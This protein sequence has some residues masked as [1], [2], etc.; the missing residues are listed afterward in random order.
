M[1]STKTQTATAEKTGRKVANG[2]GNE[3]MNNG[4]T[5]SQ[6]LQNSF[7]EFTQGAWVDP[8][9]KDSTG[10]IE[11][12]CSAATEPG[13]AIEDFRQWVN[14]EY[15]IDGFCK[16]ATNVERNYITYE[17]EN[18]AKIGFKGR[19]ASVWHLREI[20]ELVRGGVEPEKFTEIFGESG[21][22]TGVIEQIKELKRSM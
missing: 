11:R 6:R 1:H 7:K 21:T 8:F 18:E 16:Y 5:R 3:L 4:A 19:G 13:K 20:I 9:L 14:D 12:M 15:G 22:S 2:S 17:L 10:T